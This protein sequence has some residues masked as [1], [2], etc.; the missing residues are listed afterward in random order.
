MDI[1][2]DACQAPSGDN[3]Q[4]WRFEVHDNEIRVFNI[5]EKD[6]S[7]FNWN[8][9]TNHVA[10]GACIENLRIS[11]EGHGYR[12]T[13][14]FFPKPSDDRFVA[15]AVLE[16]DPSVRNALAPYISQR[17]TNRKKN[18]RK[19]I[20]PEKL[21]ELAG[22]SGTGGRVV[23]IAADRARIK[24]LAHTVSGGEKLAL[25]NR[26]VHDFL[27]KHVTWTEAE[28]R[29]KHGFFIKTFE[30]AP[31]QKIVFRLLRRWETLR[32]LLP[33]G[34]STFVAHEMAKVHATAGA[35]G[36]ILVRKDDPERFVKAGMLLERLWLTATELGLFIQPTVT[37]H[38]IGARVLAGEPGT[39]SERHQQF[40]SESYAVL[41]REF[42]L[43]DSEYFGFV[44]RI[45]Y[46]KAPSAMTTRAEP[47]VMFT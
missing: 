43:H 28:D 29:L 12:A 5:P 7:L 38:F 45:G 25:E 37:M 47:S 15:K 42:G 41:A 26:S 36:A 17:S 44:F 40:L 14:T 2:R 24:R 6:T 30:F 8:Q 9:Q 18:I 32:A 31:P 20:E 34:I 39:L 27:F 10:I 11:A 35:F 3:V 21:A 1:L 4:P 13:L 16:R 23:F 19:D 33:F 22:L 46:A